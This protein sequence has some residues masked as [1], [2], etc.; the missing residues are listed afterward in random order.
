MKTTAMM[1]RER[2]EPSPE[3][4]EFSEAVL[5]KVGRLGDVGSWAPD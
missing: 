5:E 3:S 2:G 1:Q 4:G